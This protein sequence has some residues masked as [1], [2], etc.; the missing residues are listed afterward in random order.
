MS[1]LLEIQ[2]RLFDND[3]E[4]KR[5]QLEL[6]KKP[7]DF[8]IAISLESVEK[9]GNELRKAFAEEAAKLEESVLDYRLCVNDRVGISQVNSIIDNF[10]NLFSLVYDAIATKKPKNT[11][12]ITRQAKEETAFALGYTYSGS[13]GIALTLKT[14]K[15]NLFGSDIDLAMKETL[16]MINEE[17]P[18]AVRHLVLRYGLGTF[19]ALKAWVNSHVT[20]NIE[21]EINWDKSTENAISKRVELP[22]LN[23]MKQVLEP[24]DS[25]TI[26]EI[27]E[28][29]GILQGFNYAASNFNIKLE[30][31]NEDEVITGT[32]DSNLSHEQTTGKMYNFKIVK[33]IQINNTGEKVSYILTDI[34]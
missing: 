21:A 24:T 34:M 4:A 23:R 17:T 12:K 13:I 27:I 22:K 3:A 14:P 26:E 25:Q 9:F 7:N 6:A 20:N 19:K 30:D 18:E 33:R 5:L 16:K 28:T 32:I 10:Q 1:A 11:A 31:D 8:G 29:S 15:N 2:S